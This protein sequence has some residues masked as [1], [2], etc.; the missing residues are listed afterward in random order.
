MITIARIVI[1]ISISGQSLSSLHPIALQFLAN[2]SNQSP[3]G[4][5]SR[6]WV[7][8]YF[9]FL[10]LIGL[11]CFSDFGISTDEIQQRNIGQTSLTFLAHYFELPNL[12]NGASLLADPASVF[13]LQK[14]RDY[15]VIFE[16]PAE[17]L[18]TLLNLEGKNI[19]YFRHWLT[20]IVFF[21]GTIFFY[22]TVANR[23][24]SWR[25]SLLAATLL[26]LS[27]RIFG[28]A[29][30]NDK[31]LVFLSL[32]AIA[33]YT[34][35]GFQEKPNLRNTLCHALACALAIDARIM[36][37][38]IPLLTLGVMGIRF[39]EAPSARKSILAFA[40]IY[41][42]LAFI[43]VI[44]FW[45]WLWQDPFVNLLIAFKNMARFRHIVDMVFMGKAISSSNVPWTYVPVWLGVTTPI[46][47]SIL[48]I[49]GV[50]AIA[51]QTFKA[52]WQVLRQAGPFQ[53]LI[54]IVLFFAPLGAVIV[55]HSVLYNGWRQMYFIYPAF[56]VIATRGL[57]ALWNLAKKGRFLKPALVIT[58]TLCLSYTAY[59]MVRWHPYQYLYFNVLAG[60]SSKRFDVDY[61]G[62]AYREPLEKILGQSSSDTFS[63]HF[64][65]IDQSAKWG[66]WQMDYL[67]NLPLFAKKDSDRI[68]I[69]RTEA[70]SD[71]VFT[72]L[73]G[74]RQQ[75]LLN[76]PEFSIFHELKVDGQIVYTTF[77]RN[78][79][80]YEHYAPA[81]GKVIDFGSRNTQCFLTQDWGQN[82]DWGVWSTGADPQL[83]LFM[84]S[85]K[86]HTLTL[87]MRAFINPQH[88]KQQVNISI[89]GVPQKSAT[90][91]KAD[92][93]SIELA[94]PP[95]S[96]GKEWINLSFSL[97]LAISPKELGMGED[98]RKLAIGLKSAVFR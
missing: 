63:I 25:W 14:D 12:L 55:L 67:R 32:F 47:Y 18:V 57:V 49:V 27:P 71:Y 15:G 44:I 74:N 87:D 1:S 33:S 45:P 39:I 8:L 6:F 37:I 94:I 64:I 26:I 76:K 46:L 86:P 9:G 31:D 88:P 54:F 96:Y 50:L 41:I 7:L 83:A 30:F 34:L 20:F 16:L 91:S 56:I 84:P 48:F 69:D 38:L 11:I 78:I 19:F 58:V 2:F 51:R 23:Y 92:N 85:G 90:L 89:N 79:N 66:Y 13:T 93:N 22:K 81:L 10:F 68:I 4:R 28:D 29:F 24:Q 80:L 65:S 70:C 21:I 3:F 35:I 42:A 73:M 52:G 40:A 98:T 95:N 82:E 5:S 61:W 72:T 77:K 53:D 97:P 43:L 75:Y 62:V 59:W 17:A 36:G 60:Q